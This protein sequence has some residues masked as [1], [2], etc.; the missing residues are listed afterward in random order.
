MCSEG[1]VNKG[2]KQDVDCIQ[3]LYS[4]QFYFLMNIFRLKMKLQNIL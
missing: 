3:L 1:T 2:M 4:N